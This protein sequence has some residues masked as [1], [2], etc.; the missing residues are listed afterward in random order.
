M[1]INTFAVAVTMLEGGKKNLSIAQVKEVLRV[2][3]D[4][5]DGDLYKA[6][7]KRRDVHL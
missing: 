2:I 1:K 5:L 6:I 4:L 7:R 3:N